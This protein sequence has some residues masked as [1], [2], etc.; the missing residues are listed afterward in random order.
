MSKYADL[1]GFITEAMQ[2]DK[3][4][5]S[6]SRRVLAAYPDRGYTIEGVRAHVKNFII[7]EQIRKDHPALTDECDAVGI[8]PNSV[9]H[10]WYKGENFSIHAKNKQ[11]S[12]FDIRDDIISEMKAHAPKY[13]NIRFNERKD[14]NLLVIS[15]ADIHIGKLCSIF[16][17]GD[18]YDADIAFNRVL[19]GVDGI[20]GK[21]SGMKLDKILFIA[22]ND[23]LH[24]D[25]PR[26]TTTSGTFQDT[27]LMWYD[28]FKKAQSLLVSVIE[29]LIPIAPIQID[30][31]P[32]NHDFTNGFF[33]IDTISSWF[34]KVNTVTFN[35]DMRHRKYF[36]YHNNLIGSTH[37]DGA[38][39]QD[40]GFLM[41]HEASEYWHNCKHR[42]IYTHHLHHK[43]SKDYMSVCVETLRSPSGT[44]GWHH[45][46]GYQHAPKAI[47]GFVHDKQHG[48]IMRLTH[49]F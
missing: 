33:L 1:R 42:Y 4:P 19:D 25:T 14:A 46:N 15:P 26:S 48:Q 28:A 5:I 21:L 13:P 6:I 43:V 11:P 36:A 30:Y 2:T 23:I 22:G 32:S 7:T 41:A 9:N 3:S 49:L 31:N 34:N 8:D 20:L 17:T 37:G 16:E 18:T 35:S 45:R 47:E 39:Q 10:Y 24:I 44:D 12:Y 29:R 40:L 38:K 27:H